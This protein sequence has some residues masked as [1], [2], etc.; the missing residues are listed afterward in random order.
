MN[1]KLFVTFCVFIV[2]LFLFTGLVVSNPERASA[3]SNL[4][5]IKVTPE[6]GIVGSQ[7]VISGINFPGTLATIYWDKRVAAQKVPIAADGKFS[8]TMTVPESIKGTHVIGVMDNSNWEGSASESN[9][10]IKPGVKLFPDV[11]DASS[12]MTI[13][14]NGFGDRESGIKVMLD[15]K[16]VAAD[17]LKSDWNGNWSTIVSF[18]SITKGRHTLSVV[19]GSS[20]ELGKSDL[21]FIVSPWCEINP[22]TGPVGT[23]IFIYAWGLRAN[24]DGLT[25][26][27]DNEIFFTNI[28][29]EVDGTLKLDGSKRELGSFL[30]GFDYRDSIFIPNTTQG[31]H[32]IG[33][34]GSSFT[35]KGTFPDFTFKVT[36]SLSLDP[37]SGKEAAIVNVTGT[38][39]GPDEVITLKYDGKEVATGIKVDATG[40]FVTQYTVP[41][42]TIR[43]HTFSA[44][45]NKSNSANATFTLEKQIAAAV[46][47]LTSPANGAQVSSFKSVGDVYVGSFEYI[48]GLF[49]FLSG[50]QPARKSLTIT[51]L[52]WSM[53]ANTGPW[54][55]ELQVAK[56]KNFSAPVINKTLSATEYN[57]VPG[58]TSSNGIYYWR[59]RGL[60]VVGTESAWSSVNQF[61]VVPMSTQ[62]GLISLLILILGIAAIVVIILVAR[63][64]IAR[65]RMQ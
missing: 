23:Q 58:D 53:P 40:T 38:G 54:T 24:E 17:N 2:S 8:Y 32:I 21:G 47:S 29:A 11:I 7:V 6:S 26:T 60:D 64:V 27:L 63:K 13:Y 12:S 42:G 50:G 55:Y 5:T 30:S 46:P 45:G 49:S 22:L 1:Q 65:N 20:A 39:F 48:G 15:G 14:G 41:G 16:S 18:N 44:T 35:P 51:T 4:T 3:A 19:S 10:T 28:R 36:P 43:D 56:D 37:K 34:Y 33:V 57:Y 9:Y 31:D 59:V 52:K 61:E 25:I 62:V